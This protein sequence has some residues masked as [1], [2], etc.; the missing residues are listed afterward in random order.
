MTLVI[1]TN[2]LPGKLPE[3]L[4]TKKVQAV[5]LGDEVRLIPVSETTPECPFQGMFKDGKTSI[6]N[7]LA[8][9]RVEKELEQ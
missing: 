7:F 6:D 2:T 8:K 5:R 4:K 3:M 9:K 1:E